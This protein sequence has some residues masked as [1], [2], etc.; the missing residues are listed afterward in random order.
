MCYI[1]FAIYCM[2]CTFEA[3]QGCHDI[4]V[5]LNLCSRM[6]ICNCTEIPDRNTIWHHHLRKGINL[7]CRHVNY[8]YVFF[9]SKNI[10]QYYKLLIKLMSLINFV[11]HNCNKNVPAFIKI[12]ILLVYYYIVFFKNGLFV[13]VQKY[14]KI[15][16]YLL[17]QALPPKKWWSL[18]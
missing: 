17:E 3:I 12:F 5:L 16:L 2:S 4:F 15:L 18:C 11:P 13:C 1:I 9:F 8:E 6:Q 7:A 10:S 14:C